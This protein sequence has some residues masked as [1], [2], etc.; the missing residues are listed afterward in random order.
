M[1]LTRSLTPPQ[2]PGLLWELG[3]VGRGE[4]AVTE[5][6]RP[7]ACVQRVGTASMVGPGSGGTST[8]LNVRGVDLNVSLSV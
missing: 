3:E 8:L 7:W 2:M 6:T 5:G 4:D 1:P